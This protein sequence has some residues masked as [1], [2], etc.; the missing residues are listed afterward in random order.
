MWMMELPPSQGRIRQPLGSISA[1]TKQVAGGPVGPPVEDVNDLS[2]I[3][4][5]NP[6]LI[7]GDATGFHGN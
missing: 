1:L 2:Q 5:N 6:V 3:S 7:E 4:R